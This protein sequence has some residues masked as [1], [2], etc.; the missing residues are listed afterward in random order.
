MKLPHRGQF[1]HLA[2]GAAAALLALSCSASAQA[3][4]AKTKPPKARRPVGGVRR[5]R[6]AGQPDN[7]MMAAP[8]LGLG[9]LRPNGNRPRR[10]VRRRVSGA[11][12]Q[13]DNPKMAAPEATESRFHLRL[14]DWER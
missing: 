7:P 14:F 2:A 10:G 4:P 13:P 8:A 3:Y 12:G 6:T 5:H 9:W 1:L 11:T